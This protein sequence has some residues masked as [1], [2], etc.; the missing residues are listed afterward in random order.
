MA[1]KSIKIALV[2]TAIDKMSAVVNKANKNAKAA[3]SL[4]KNSALL[5]VALAAPLYGAVEAAQAFET[6]MIDIRKQMS[7]DTPDTVK[8]MT[9]QVME[10]GMELPLATDEI[11]D[12]IAAGLRMGIAEDKVVSYTKEVTKMSSAFDIPA[13][14]IADS[15]G[16]ISNVFK[17]PIEKVGDFADAINYLDDNTMAKGP[18]LITVLQKIG[19]M[20]RNLEPK[21]AA[22][23]AAAMLSLGESPDTAGTAINGMLVNLSNAT[24]GT[25]NF[26]K[27]IQMLGMDSAKLQKTMSNPLT[28][29]NGIISVFEKINKLGKDKQSEVLVRLFGKEHGP[30]LTKLATGIEEYKRQLGLVNGAEKGSMNKEYQKRVQSSVAQ[31]QMFKNRMTEVTVKAGTA[32][33]PTFNKLALSVGKLVEKISAFIDRNPE[34]VSWLTK[35]IAFSAGLSFA[36]SGL[37]FAFGGVSKIISYTTSTLK[38]LRAGQLA[39]LTATA[40]GSS[41]SVSFTAALKAMNMAFLTNPIFLIIAGIATAALLIYTY[42]EPIKAF[43]INLWN[44][45]SGPLS[46]LWEFI[47]MV[48]WN[49]SPYGIVIKNWGKIANFFS[50]LWS[51]I[52]K[53]F[54]S[55][56]QLIKFLFLNFTPYGLI[57]KHWSSIT[58]FFSWIWNNVKIIFSKVWNWIKFLFLNFTPYG[59]IIKHWSTISAFFSKVWAKVKDIF[60]SAVSWIGNLHLKFFNAGK[61]M[62]SAIWNG[63]KAMASKPIEAIKAIVGKIRDFFPFSPAKTGPLKDIHKIKLIETIANTIKP[64]S[65]VKAV[66]DVMVKVGGISGS[67]NNPI[68]M[69]PFNGGSTV[70]FSPVINLS[71]SATKEDGKMITESLKSQ[72]NRLMKEHKEN[73]QRIAY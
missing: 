69:N 36:V 67:N 43:F 9:A 17:I 42:W 66:N 49:F 70:H 58:K 73:K 18:E 59:L 44:K 52:K 72:F 19:G 4:G 26:Q 63:I 33:L 10:L 48:F 23:L 21:K 11:Q 6:K 31:W 51:G 3:F 15:M 45:I 41:A 34:L 20:A 50:G 35:A 13:G 30:K 37:S 61:N 12:M 54:N 2:L 39:Y 62:V 14:E 25:K 8:K 22:A 47:K 46:I 55:G 1:D 27:G 40:A 56:L 64:K 24:M 32:F 57:F 71:G 5:G 7:V 53:I 65:L 38:I 60:F 28:A 16:K 29:Q 68:R